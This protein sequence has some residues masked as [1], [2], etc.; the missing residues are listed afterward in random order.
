MAFKTVRPAGVEAFDSAR[1]YFDNGRKVTSPAFSGARPYLLQAMV[2]VSA[3]S[4]VIQGEY[5][6]TWKADNEWKR[7]S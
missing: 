4:G 5:T 1:S 7:D 6:D 3:P 2:Q